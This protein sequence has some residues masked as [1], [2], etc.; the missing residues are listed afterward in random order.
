MS[1]DS[2]GVEGNEESYAPS[3]SE[4]GRYVAFRTLS[5]N[6]VPGDANLAEDV[7]VHDRLHG[8]TH[9]ASLA[10]DGT[11]GNANSLDPEISADGRFVVY[12]SGASNLVGGDANLAVDAFLH[13]RRSGG[14]EIEATNLVAGATATL[15]ITGASPG[16]EVL[17]GYSTVGQDAWG[18]PVGILHLA[19]PY[20]TRRLVADGQGQIV[21]NF[22]LAGSLSGTPLWFQGV[23]MVTRYPTSVAPGRIQ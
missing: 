5:S 6:L 21:R 1:V 16:G 4:D 19:S 23:D 11:E 17:L 7:F 14:A 3:V 10:S 18:S 20:Q 12:E 2:Y 13:D 22:P 15:T 9:R 8:F